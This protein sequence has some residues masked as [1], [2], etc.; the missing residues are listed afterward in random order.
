MP[1]CELFNYKLIRNIFSWPRGG[2][3]SA[4]SCPA[5]WGIC[6]IL[7]AIKTSIPE[8]GGGGGFT[9]TGALYCYNK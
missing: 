6:H 4:I 3:F 5:W 1:P 9:L 8:E 7:H 2:A